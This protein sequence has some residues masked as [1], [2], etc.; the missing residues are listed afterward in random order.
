MNSYSHEIGA[1]ILE[2]VRRKG[3]NAY[4]STR[5]TEIGRDA[6]IQQGP[7]QELLYDERY[8]LLP[9]AQQPSDPSSVMGALETFAVAHNRETPTIGLLG[10]RFPWTGFRLREQNVKVITPEG[11]Y[12][13]YDL[14]LSALDSI[15][16]TSMGQRS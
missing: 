16:D 6:V 4:L 13:P 12:I 7:A 15:I 10:Q 3:W 14:F 2:K 5:S 1:R 9:Q 11:H 8:A